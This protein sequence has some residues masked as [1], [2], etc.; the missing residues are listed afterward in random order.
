MA[1]SLARNAGGIFDATKNLANHIKLIEGERIKVNVAGGCDPQYQADIDKWH[2]D[3]L[4]AHDIVGPAGFG[5]F[6]KS[7]GILNDVDIF[8]LHGLWAYPS[9]VLRQWQLKTKKVSIISPHGMLQATALEKSRMKKNV[10]WQLCEKHNFKAANCIHALSDVEAQSIAKMGVS[11][12]ICVIPNGVCLPNLNE[13]ENRNGKERKKLL[14]LARIAPIKNL[15]NLIEA[16]GSNNHSSKNEWDLEIVGWGEKEYVQKI[17]E[18]IDYHQ[19]KGECIKYRGPLFDKEKDRCF[20]EA[21]A[22]V[23]PS[24]GEGHPLSVLEA[25][26][27]ALPTIVTRQCNVP[28]YITRD[29]GIV[30]DESI[31][32]LSSALD[33]L[34]SKSKQQLKEEGAEARNRMEKYYS[35]DSSVES[36]LEVYEW[37]LGGSRPNCLFSN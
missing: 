7:K 24:L 12:P 28:D 9:L 27:H 26:S 19:N 23:L 37:T 20:A 31:E 8:H 1:F 4:S 35:W 30:V 3:V 11:A 15:E 2:V 25:M 22:Y 36:M 17:V 10:M 21:D 18:L 34:F 33:Q 6:P 29:C 13:Y 32:D 14:F 5:Y 16:W